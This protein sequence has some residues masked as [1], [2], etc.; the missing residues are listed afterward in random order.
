MKESMQESFEA[1]MVF[2][3][4]PNA[5]CIDEGIEPSRREINGTKAGSSHRTYTSQESRKEEEA[6]GQEVSGEEE[7]DQTGAAEVGAW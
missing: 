7:G 5:V 4:S 3:H 6:G 2:L 1:M